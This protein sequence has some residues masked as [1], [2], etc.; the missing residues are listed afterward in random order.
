MLTK[1]DIASIRAAR[2]PRHLHLV[3]AFDYPSAPCDSEPRLVDEGK[4]EP[5]DMRSFWKGL[6]LF[7]CG[8]LA[9]WAF[10]AAWQ[11]G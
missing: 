2:R 10:I 1:A 11:H 9:A 3:S 4:W 5:T 6:F 8:A 7:A